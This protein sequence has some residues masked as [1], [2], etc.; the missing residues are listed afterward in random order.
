MDLIQQSL[1]P[2]IVSSESMHLVY[3]VLALILCTCVAFH[4]HNEDQR[5]H[6][7]E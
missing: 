3:I 1:S 2:T 6:L 7:Y 4:E 5:I